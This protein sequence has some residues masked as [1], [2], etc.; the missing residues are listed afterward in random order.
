MNSVPERIIGLDLGDRWS[1]WVELNREGEEV[2][3]G[4]IRTTKKAMCDFFF[5]QGGES[6]GPGGR[7]ALGMGITV[8]DQAGL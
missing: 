7:D 5:G 2:S 8:I 1:K 4:R 3:R 6:S